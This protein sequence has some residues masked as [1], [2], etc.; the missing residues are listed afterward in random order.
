MVSILTA[1]LAQVKALL[2][3]AGLH[4]KGDAIGKQTP[5]LSLSCLNSPP[6]NLICS[7]TAVVSC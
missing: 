4:I 6:K 3:L 1:A 7:N 5:L 2:L